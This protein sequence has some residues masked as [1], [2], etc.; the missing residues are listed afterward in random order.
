MKK[1]QHYRRLH[2]DRP[3]R[4]CPD[5]LSQNDEGGNDILCCMQFGVGSDWSEGT[6]QVSNTLAAHLNNCKGTDNH[7]FQWIQLST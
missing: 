5:S 3:T 6:S 2:Y 4:G 7:T 1:Q